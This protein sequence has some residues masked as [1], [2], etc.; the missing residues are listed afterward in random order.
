MLRSLE[1]KAKRRRGK[2]AGE[3]EGVTWQGTFFQ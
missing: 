1:N 2:E 3:Q